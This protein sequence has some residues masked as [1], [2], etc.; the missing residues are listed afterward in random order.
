MTLSSIKNN[1]KLN[2]DHPKVEDPPAP[3]R[4]PGGGVRGQKKYFL[5]FFSSHGV[6]Q[7]AKNRM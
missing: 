7:H 4:P 3:L 2:F 6:E 1:V 5:I